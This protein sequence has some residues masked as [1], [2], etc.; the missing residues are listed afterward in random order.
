MDVLES[1]QQYQ[2][3]CEPRSEHPRPQA[4]PQLQQLPA[5]D[6]HQ[7]RDERAVDEDERVV[8]PGQEVGVRRRARQQEERDGREAREAE[9]DPAQRLRHDEVQRHRE[10][11]MA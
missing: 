6:E 11:I 4:S 9:R 1:E 8:V 10:T 3:Q 2:P 5:D 7:E